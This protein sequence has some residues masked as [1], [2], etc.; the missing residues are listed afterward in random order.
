MSGSVKLSYEESEMMLE[1]GEKALVNKGSGEIVKQ[2][3]KNPNVLAWKT[4]V[5]RFNNTPLSELIAVIEKVYNKDIVVL[6]P[7]LL[8]C[9]ITA[10]FEGETFESVLQVVKSTLDI[11][12]RPNGNMIE[13]SGEGCE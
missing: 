4:K 13:F 7:D 1:P 9:R 8:K 12:I 10:T 11:T 3:N 5:L 6:N 2:Q